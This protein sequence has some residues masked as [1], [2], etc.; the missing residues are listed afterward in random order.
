[1]THKCEQAF[2]DFMSVPSL[3]HPMFESR[4]SR[5]IDFSGVRRVLT[6]IRIIS[7]EKDSVCSIKKIVACGSLLTNK[8]HE[9][10]KLYCANCKQKMEMG[11]LCYMAI[12]KNELPRLDNALFVLYDFEQLKIRSFPIRQHCVFQI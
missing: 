9:C 4:V 10:N 7:Y 5:I 12:L 2:S 3:H 6:S 11:L 8:K 1:M